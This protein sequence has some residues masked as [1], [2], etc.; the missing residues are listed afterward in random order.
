MT[1]FSIIIPAYNVADF[2]PVC[3]DSVLSQDF[4]DYEIILV[5]D[6]ST[7]G[8]SEICDQYQKSRANYYKKHDKNTPTPPSS[9]IVSQI[10]KN[11]K[12]KIQVIHQP[13]AGLSE[14]R[15]SGIKI[16]TGE[17]LLFLDG[18]DSLAPDTL[19]KIASALD[20]S[21]SALPLDLLRFQCQDLLENGELLPHP[22][23]GFSSMPGLAAFPLL[24]R[25]HY[26]ENAWLYCYR[27]EFFKSNHFAYAKG[28]LAEDFGLTPLII[29][30]AT[31]VAAIP[32]IC[33]NYRLRPGSI[34]HDPAKLHRR[35]ADAYAGL[36]YQLPLLSAQ[37]P[38]ST[39]PIA[40]YLSVSF[41]TLASTLPERDFLQFY[42]KFTAAG[43]KKYLRPQ[44]LRNIPRT[45]LLRHAPKLYRYFFRP[46]TNL[47]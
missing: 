43:F 36:E 9:T 33:Y 29:A 21:N 2:L 15:N 12:S 30:R 39:A 26:T 45:F 16:A 8:T 35:V 7:D 6:G 10:D 44:S 3:L 24:A 46:N 14:A 27:T 1:K 13:N 23:P 22:D 18:D 11:V 4:S 34:M 42:Q 32:D 25:S 31:S 20:H 17:Y 37:D 47:S 28:R 5:D 40:H 19:A 41:L 38:K